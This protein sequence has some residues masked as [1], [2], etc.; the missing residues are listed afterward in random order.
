[1]VVD[2]DIFALDDDDSDI[3][4]LDDDHHNIFAPVYDDSDFVVTDGN[5]S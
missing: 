5:Y 2:R 4:A 1:M 3:F